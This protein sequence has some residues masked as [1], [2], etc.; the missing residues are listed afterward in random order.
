MKNRYLIWFLCLTLAAGGCG[1]KDQEIDS[2]IP[3]QVMS[4]VERDFQQRLSFPGVTTTHAVSDVGFQVSGE[5]VSM[6]ARVG[7]RV[8]AGSLL[9]ALDDSV[10]RDE[11]RAAEAQ[12][13][14][15]SSQLAEVKA[16]SRPQEL[17]QAKS[18]V[19][20]AKAVV[21]QAEAGRTQAQANLELA[22]VELKRYQAVYDAEAVSLQKLQ[23]VESQY[24]V[25]R[26]QFD[27]SGHQVQ[28]ARQGVSQAKAQYSLAL[29]GARPEQV[30]TARANLASAEARSAQAHNRLKYT[31]LAAPFSGVVTRKHAEVGQVVGA[32]TPV[33]EIRSDGSLE[34]EIQVPSAHLQRMVP[35]LKAE[36]TFPSISDQ[37][38]EAE[39]YEIQPV[40]DEKVRNFSVKLRLKEN[41]FADHLSGVI[42]QAS[43]AFGE[44]V[45][46]IEVPI[47]AVIQ[48]D[49]AFA[50][51]ILDEQEQARRVEVKLITIRDDRARISGPV[52][53]GTRVITS[54]QEFVQEGRPVR[55]VEALGSSDIVTPDRDDKNRAQD[56]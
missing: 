56:G 38:V 31:H 24:K 47:S 43:F 27:A 11:A 4:A 17:D 21:K 42:G 16:G 49:G 10:Y 44:S 28:Q 5:I 37:T 23:Q 26:E 20:H 34:L 55:V 32:G 14:V 6:N 1:K 13:S 45:P 40:N 19:E 22:R 52:Q 48:R 36:V 50:V 25:A 29:E 30:D 53:T 41:P 35:G 15:A 2:R 39:V 12:V 51:M 3:V 33:Y 8:V 9:A 46:G 54:G 7:Q 18:S